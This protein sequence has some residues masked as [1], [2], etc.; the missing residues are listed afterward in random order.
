MPRVKVIEKLVVKQ[1]TVQLL[2][3]CTADAFPPAQVLSC[4][5]YCTYI[6]VYPTLKLQVKYCTTD[7]FDTGTFPLNLLFLR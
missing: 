2:L 4:S 3:Y 5:L 6:T 1:C 7:S